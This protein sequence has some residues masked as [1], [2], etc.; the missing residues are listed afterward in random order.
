MVNKSQEEKLERIQCCLAQLLSREETYLLGLS[1]GPDSMALFYLLLEGQWKFHVCHVIH[2]RVKHKAFSLKDKKNV[3][4]F[5]QK[6]A[7]KYSIPFYEEVCSFQQDQ[8]FSCEARLARFHVFQ[9][10][11]N[12]EKCAGLL[13]GHHA[14]DQVETILKR[15]FEGA[16]FS[17]VLGM[18]KSHHVYHMKVI[19]PLL[20]FYKEDLLTWL[21]HRGGLFVNDPS[22]EDMSILR[23]RMRKECLPFLEHTFQKRIKENIF[24]LQNRLQRVLNYV[25]K[26]IQSYFLE[27]IK[28]PYG[29]CL[30]R[31]LLQDFVEV[32]FLLKRIFREANMEISRREVEELFVWLEENR[33]SC[34]M[35]RKLWK[36]SLERDCIFLLFSSMEIEECLILPLQEND[37]CLIE[38]WKNLW[39]KGSMKVFSPIGALYRLDYP[40]LKQKLPNGIRLGEWYRRHKVPVF[41]R[42]WFPVVWSENRLIGEYLTG[43]CYASDH[44]IFANHL[45]T[46]KRKVFKMK[47]GLF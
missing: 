22:N 8:N 11:Y 35:V 28:G 41:F 40:V 39:E 42:S 9:K 47:A 33:S 26:R 21:K 43:K 19:R 6:E 4:R 10:I 36:I 3:S 44:K 27:T 25:D 18:K 23:V 1:G 15:I 29:Y 2:V 31:Y 13:L 46:L 37:E 12:R 38:D 32:E 34:K 45:L 14:D 7:E 24:F 5:V 17:S 30:P 16:S 20:P